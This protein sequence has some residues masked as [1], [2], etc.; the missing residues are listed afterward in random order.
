MVVAPA[1]MANTEDCCAIGGEPTMA[2]ANP[3]K[4][5]H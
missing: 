2:K 1:H 3:A 5:N 4:A